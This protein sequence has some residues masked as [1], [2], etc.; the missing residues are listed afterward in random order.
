[1]GH[2]GPK[3][4]R[5]IPSASLPSGRCSSVSFHSLLAA[6]SRLKSEL[7]RHGN[8]RNSIASRAL[9]PRPSEAEVTCECRGDLRMQSLHWHGLEMHV[10]GDIDALIAGIRYSCS[11]LGRL[12]L[13]QKVVWSSFCSMQVRLR[14]CVLQVPVLVKGLEGSV[15]TALSGQMK[16]SV[17]SRSFV[18]KRPRSQVTHLASMLLE[19]SCGKQ[20]TMPHSQFVTTIWFFSCRMC[21]AFG[22]PTNI[23]RSTQTCKNEH[24]HDGGLC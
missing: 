8:P 22:C 11:H 23:L 13:H 6:A 3:G 10:G 12:H 4:Y 15:S 7:W 1:M 24:Q 14:S 5:C 16:S 18:L 17:Q 19:P 20:M 21:G 2:A 9:K